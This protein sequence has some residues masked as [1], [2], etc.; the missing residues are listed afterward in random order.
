MFSQNNSFFFAGKK[1][2]YY[3]E[4]I[5]SQTV[6]EIKVQFLRIILTVTSQYSNLGNSIR[7]YCLNVIITEKN[8]VRMTIDHFT[9]LMIPNDPF[10]LLPNAEQALTSTIYNITKTS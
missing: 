1:G 5:S 4:A 6:C 10:H 2:I 8:A 9:F 7:A 3:S